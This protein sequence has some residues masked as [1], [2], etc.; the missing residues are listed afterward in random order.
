MD[1]IAAE[2]LPE[3]GHRDHK[4][5]SMQWTKESA[6]QTDKSLL[7]LCTEYSVHWD[8][9]A[10]LR[11]EASPSPPSQSQAIV[12]ADKKAR[13]ARSEITKWYELKG[14]PWPYVHTE[15]TCVSD[16]WL[17]HRVGS[18]QSRVDCN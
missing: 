16:P 10:S 17:E 14:E 8:T 18:N 12:R 1:V 9:V 4:I 7:L 11:A 2:H 6:L 3:L 15:S 5:I 13:N